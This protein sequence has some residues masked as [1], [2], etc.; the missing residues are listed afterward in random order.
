[1]KRKMKRVVITSLIIPMIVLSGCPAYDPPSDKRSVRDSVSDA[2]TML[3][4]FYRAYM[5]TIAI[6]QPKISN[7]K[8]DSLRKHYCTKQLIDNIERKWANNDLDYDPFFNA[9]DADTSNL[10]SLQIYKVDQAYSV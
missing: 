5:M 1:M 4:N 2:S 6:D 7:V 3:K 10:K 9:Q 8:C